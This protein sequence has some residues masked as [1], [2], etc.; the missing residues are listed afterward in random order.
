M[1]IVDAGVIV[2]VIVGRIAAF[3][4]S[5]EALIAPHLIDSEVT[6]ALRRHVAAGLLT[7]TQGRD[8][9]LHFA[10][11]DIE[12]RPVTAHLSRIWE[13]RHTLTAYDATY[14]ALAEALDAD[15]LLTTDA[16]LARAPGIRCPVRVL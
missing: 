8:G 15:V 14:V 4:E 2:D 10:Q 16:R 7:E 11:L 12:R 6:H 13:L 9:L 1:K 5:A 3:D